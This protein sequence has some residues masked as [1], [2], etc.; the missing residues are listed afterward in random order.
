[1]MGRM[2]GFMFSA[3]PRLV[4]EAGA[5]ASKVGSLVVSLGCRAVTVVTTPG[6]HRRGQTA[7]L[8]AGLERAGLRAAVWDRVTP[9]PPEQAVIQ[10]VQFCRD[11]MTDG[12]VRTNSKT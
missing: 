10:L 6:L 12:V 2:A 5:A 8:L 7:G 4:F 11:N 3:G 9:D 1:M